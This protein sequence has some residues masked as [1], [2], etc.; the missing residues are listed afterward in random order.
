MGRYPYSDRKTVEECKDIDV[1]WLKRHDYFCGF[2]NG[3]LRTGGSFTA[4]DHRKTRLWG[5]IEWKNALVEV[6]GSMGIEVS[7]L[8]EKYVRLSYTQT[9]NFTEDSIELDYKIELVTTPC[10]FGGF[11][12]WFICPLREVRYRYTGRVV[13]GKPCK[14]RVGKLYL[15]PSAKYFGCRHCYNLTYKCQ[16]EHDKRV[17]VLKKNPELIQK[18]LLVI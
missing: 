8:G 11:R 1:F 14:R 12:Y 5:G 13:E 6:I 7:V 16:K 18:I 3:H 4:D 9:N 2:K 17:D 10:N 15:P